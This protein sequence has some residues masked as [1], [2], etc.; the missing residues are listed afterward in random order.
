MTMRGRIRA[1]VAVMTIVTSPERREDAGRC[2]LAEGLAGPIGE[3]LLDGAEI[4]GGV[5]RQVGA[6]G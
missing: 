5:L 3:A 2:A 4:G 1:V 6:L